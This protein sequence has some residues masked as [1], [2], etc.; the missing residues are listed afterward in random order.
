MDERLKQNIEKEKEGYLV[1]CPKCGKAQMR[2]RMA[3]SSCQC[4]RCK[5]EFYA[6][7]TE[8][9]V[10]L[11]DDASVRQWFVRSVECEQ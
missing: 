4:S 8:K 1:C 2:G 7:V 5:Y 9:S 10:F 3:D 6:Y 11:T